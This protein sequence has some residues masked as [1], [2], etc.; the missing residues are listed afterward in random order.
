L[1]LSV[2]LQNK[3]YEQFDEHLYSLGILSTRVGYYLSNC[4]DVTVNTIDEMLTAKCIIN[5]H[6][7]DLSELFAKAWIAQGGDIESEYYGSGIDLFFH[8]YSDQEQ[9][10]NTLIR[11]TRDQIFESVKTKVPH[12]FIP[13]HF[14]CHSSNF[15]NSNYSPGYNIV[16]NDPNAVRK[17]VPKVQNLIRYECIR[18]LKEHDVM[19]MFEERYFE[20]S[21]FDTTFKHMYGLS[22]ED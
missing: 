7:S 12:E 1:V 2:I 21:F 13:K 15:D 10:I 19:N 14:L 17:S 9:Y 16:F 6:R 20:I 11:N 18:L 8:V 3:V 5:K 22:R 4:V